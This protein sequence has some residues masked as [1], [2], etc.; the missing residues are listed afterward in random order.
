MI[1][2]AKTVAVLGLGKMGSAIADAV[3]AKGHQVAVWNRS[4]DKAENQTAAGAVLAATPADAVGSA[5]IILLCVIDADACEEI[6]AT[7]GFAAALKEKTLVQFSTMTSDESSGFADWAKA[8]GAGYLDGS[9]LGLPQGVR[10]G[11]LKI[12]YSGPEALFEGV[13]SVLNT[14]GEPVW[15]GARHGTAFLADKIIYTQYYGIHFT[16]LLTA[17][18]GQAAGIPVGSLKALIGGEDRWKA[19]GQMIDAALEMAA[20]GDY[21]NVECALDVHLAAFQHAVRISKDMGIG[22]EFTKMIERTM[23]QAID[24]GHAKDE[25][26]SIFEAL[27]KKDK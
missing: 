24:S 21:S 23:Q 26:A 9:I 14:L 13:E 20:K 3:I 27:I 11:T 17:A 16:Y 7:E 25:L 15:L 22:I 5:G 1:Q 6:F 10:D 2:E 19:R 12:L 8:A 18:L 4:P